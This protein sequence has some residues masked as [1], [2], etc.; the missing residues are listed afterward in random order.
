MLK[1]NQYNKLANQS[2]AAGKTNYHSHPLTLSNSFQFYNCNIN[3]TIN[4]I[5]SAITDIYIYIYHWTI[6]VY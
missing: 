4:N 3:S 2:G 6:A 1:I 5:V